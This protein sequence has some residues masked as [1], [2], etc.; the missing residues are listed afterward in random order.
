MW[1]EYWLT[2]FSSAHV[3]TQICKYVTDTSAFIHEYLLTNWLASIRACAPIFERV[4]LL[5]LLRWL[6]KLALIIAVSMFVNYALLSQLKWHTSF[7]FHNKRGTCACVMC[8]VGVKRIIVVSD[9]NVHNCCIGYCAGDLSG[10]VLSATRS[11]HVRGCNAFM[12]DGSFMR[13]LAMRVNEL[14]M[15][16]FV[17]AVSNCQV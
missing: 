16:D 17:V 10:E 11:A 4:L 9:C 3:I 5:V 15:F 13:W 2:T 8:K 7:F 6:I 14:F 12:L 1:L